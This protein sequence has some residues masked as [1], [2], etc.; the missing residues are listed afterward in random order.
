MPLVEKKVNAGVRNQSLVVTS[1]YL[2]MSCLE[3]S[4]QATWK[5]TTPAVSCQTLDKNNY[6]IPYGDEKP[7]VY[8]RSDHPQSSL[9]F[10]KLRFL[11][12]F[13]ARPPEE[14]VHVKPH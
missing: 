4:A 11:Q 2:R 10:R 6:F 5:S 12:K 14:N 9:P 8:V 1:R 13:G 3:F 7:T